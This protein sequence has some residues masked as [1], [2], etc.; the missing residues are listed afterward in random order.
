MAH[1]SNHGLNAFE[2]FEDL[3]EDGL[4]SKVKL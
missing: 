1:E 3:V 4:G 2:R